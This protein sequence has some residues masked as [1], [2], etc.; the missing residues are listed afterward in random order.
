VRIQSQSLGTAVTVA[1]LEL[2]EV[3]IRGKTPVAS[4]MALPKEFLDK[5]SGFD[6]IV[7]GALDSI[8]V[9]IFSELS[10]TLGAP[11]GS[12]TG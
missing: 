11:T 4:G 3:C 5:T 2:W 9:G 6:G 1:S 10:D 12:L 7:D 8:I